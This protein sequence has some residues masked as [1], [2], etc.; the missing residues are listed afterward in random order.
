MAAQRPLKI[1]PTGT[2]ERFQNGD[3]L[4]I[5]YGG[6]DA[7]TVQQ[8][9]INLGVVPGTDVQA[10][11]QALTNLSALAG[12][13]VTIRTGA[14]SWV[15]RTIQ[16]TANRIT[17][18]NGSGVD[19]N[20]TIDLHNLHG[21]D[22]ATPQFLKFGYDRAGRVTATSAVVASD[23]TALLDAGGGTYV[24]KAGDTMTGHLT[25]VGNPVNG[26]HA[27]SKQYVDD[28]FA[29]G[30]IA[31]F[32]SVVAKTTGNHTLSGTGAVDGVT[33]TVGDRVLVASQTVASSNGIYIVAAGAW[34]R[35]ADA[36]QPAEFQPAR[37]VFV[38]SGTLYANSGWAVSSA[39]NP[40]IDT[41]PLTFTQVSGAASYSA[42]NGLDLNGNQFSAVGVAGQIIVSGG[43]IGLASGIV[44]AGTYTK[45]TVDTH[46]RVTSGAQATPQD[47]GAQPADPTLDALAGYDENGFVVQTATGTFTGRDIVGTAGQIVVDNGSGVAGNP[48]ISLATGVVAPGTYNSVTVDGHGRV[49][50]GTV[51]A[52][53][54]VTDVATNGEA[55]DMV[56]CRAVYVS[57][58]GTVKLANANA[59]PTTNVVGLVAE[60]SVASSASGSIAVAG[61]LEATTTQWDI[62]T[63]QTGGLTSGSTY[64]LSAATNG[65]ITSTAP[66]SGHIVPVGVAISPT[67]LRLGF[68]PIV[69]L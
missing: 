22:S 51:A 36:D 4:P 46:G 6:T 20:I 30:G 69:A 60:A 16:G 32:E 56:I 55:S 65:A 34:T 52:T 25:L 14:D 45:V 5:E 8:A 10:F 62:V 39:A 19:G 28:L 38:Q 15:L 50:S 7:T 31:P 18:T 40:V 48:T 27:A 35:A 53:N 26:L 66:G 13:G 41:D 29:A 43:G 23:I 63:G 37:Q 3:V 57:G 33:L 9:Q 12:T 42:G 17:I 21:A 2:I 24:S 59:F 11:S 58:P 68:G 61:V 64:F 1:N 67:K 44:T 49:T 47:I 54:V